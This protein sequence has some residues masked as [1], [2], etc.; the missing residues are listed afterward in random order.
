MSRTLLCMRVADCD[1]QVESVVR[2]CGRCSA[3]IWVTL[4]SPKADEL[5]CVPCGMTT[6]PADAE[7]VRPTRR[8]KRD[9]AKALR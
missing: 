6:M 9:I 5:L 1:P 2:S 7:I 3:A 8:Q 4:S